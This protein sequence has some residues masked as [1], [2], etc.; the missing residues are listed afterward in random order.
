MPQSGIFSCPPRILGNFRLSF[1]IESKRKTT[2]MGGI[3]TFRLFM[4]ST[5]ASEVG[6]YGPL[7]SHN[8]TF[9]TWQKH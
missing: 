4:Y 5:R 8:I 6:G 2:S 1:G 7:I 9:Q 3:A